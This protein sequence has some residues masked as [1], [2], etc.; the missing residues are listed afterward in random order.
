MNS[1]IKISL[2][3]GGNVAKAFCARLNRNKEPEISLYCRKPDEATFAHD[4]EI[5][6][7]GWPAAEI[8]EAD[9]IIIAVSD[10]AVVQTA[11][12]LSG[13]KAL[14]VHTSGPLPV[15]ILNKNI[16]RTGV[17]YPLQSL[18]P[19]TRTNTPIPLLLQ[20]TFPEDAELLENIARRIGPEYLWTNDE[21]RLSMHLNAVLVSN[22]TNHLYATSW[23]LL[24]NHPQAF[25]QLLPLIQE[26]ALRITEEDPAQW[27]TGPAIRE[28]Y[29]TM[30]THLNLLS[31][32]DSL[33]ELYRLI[34]SRIIAKEKNG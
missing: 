34:S 3:G 6:T 25:R 27:Q 16:R 21:Q 12:L 17:L 15:N 10:K 7:Y 8:P 20:T 30:E 13:T 26:T 32:D 1:A 14:V 23:Q 31:G 19:G 18:R 28:D 22:F 4:L 29:G 11:A 5:K 2:I 9:L 33:Q 24:K